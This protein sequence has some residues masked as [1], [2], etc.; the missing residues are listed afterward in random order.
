[1]NHLENNNLLS[2]VQHG[3]RRERS[4]ETQ[5]T[6]VVQDIAS[7]VG[8][9]RQ[10]DAAILDFSKAFDTVPHQRLLYK[11]DCYGIRGE[12]LRWISNFLTN[13]SQS[14]ILDGTTSNKVM[15]TSGVP[16][17]TVLGP[18][19]FLVYI[20]DLPHNMS[21]SVRLFADDCILYRPISNTGDCLKLQH[22]L[23]SLVQWEK[24]WQM[25]FNV[26]KCFV[27]TISHKKTNTGFNYSMGQ[28]V[29]E[30]VSDY[31]Y[32]GVTI[33]DDLSWSKHINNVRASANKTLGVLC[34]NLW[35]C[36]KPIKDLAYK[37]LVRPKLEYA[38]AVWDPYHSKDIDT[39]EMVQRRAARFV[40]RDYRR[41]EG[42]VTELLKDLEWPS[43][44]DRRCRSRLILLY[45]IV[46][47]LVAVDTGTLLLNPVRTTRSSSSS[48]HTFLKL[49]T[50]KDCYKYSFFPRTISEWNLLPGHIREADSLTAFKTK[51]SEI[52]IQHI[53]DSSHY[54]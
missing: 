9:S 13:R 47:N 3:F 41:E 15:V 2:S 48:R 46:N 34:R 5:L 28:Q 35:S 19:L 21:S 54:V 14:V 20:N 31:P 45:K 53:M 24:D 4:C 27:M 38:S 29:L 16:Q 50:N 49:S 39:L 42:V 6:T 44:A 8:K 26:K 25:C 37:S 12:T 52:D 30:R 40:C 22:D 32:L 10:V 7:T 1:M 51:L 17:G 33:S 18:L 23:Q 43:L 36:K 11:L